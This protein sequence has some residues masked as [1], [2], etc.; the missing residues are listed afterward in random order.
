MGFL[1]RYKVFLILKFSL[2]VP[3][4]GRTGIY[5]NRYL[6]KYPIG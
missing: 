2:I 1:L 4:N 6:L 5:R 3:G